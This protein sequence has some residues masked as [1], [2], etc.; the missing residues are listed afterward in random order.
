MRCAFH[1][2]VGHK[3]E[4]Y[5]ALKSHLEE[6]AQ[7]GHLNDFVEKRAEKV[8]ANREVRPDNVLGDDA[9]HEFVVIH[10]VSDVKQIQGNSARMEM[11]KLTAVIQAFQIDP[12]KSQSSMS[13]GRQI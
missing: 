1:K 11:K 8:T 2:E 7:F 4:H 10:G 3:I 5:K 13:R 6:L 9:G 12:A